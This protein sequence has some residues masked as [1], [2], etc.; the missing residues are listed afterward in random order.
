MKPVNAQRALY[1]AFSTGRVAVSLLKEAKEHIDAIAFSGQGQ[2]WFAG[3]WSGG[4]ARGAS[5]DPR[6]MTS[7]L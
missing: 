1:R 3:F 4:V 7:C 5:A 2:K 6:D